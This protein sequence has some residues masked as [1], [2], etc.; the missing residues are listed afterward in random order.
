[1]QLSQER[2]DAGLPD[3]KVVYDDYVR[4]AAILADAVLFGTLAVL[5]LGLAVVLLRWLTRWVLGIRI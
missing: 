4:P 2:C 1:L 3:N 5:A